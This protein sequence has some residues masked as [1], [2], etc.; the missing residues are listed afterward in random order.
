M[1]IHSS[2]SSTPTPPLPLDLGTV[3]LRA[4]IAAVLLGPVLNLANQWAAIRAGEI[5]LLPAIL[6]FSTPFLTVLA[7]QFIAYRTAV[8]DHA[9]GAGKVQFSGLVLRAAVIGAAMALLNV[10][11]IVG[12]TPR[13][14]HEPISL[15]IALV[16]QSLILP[17]LFSAVSQFL[18][19]RRLRARWAS[20]RP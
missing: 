19:H 3:I 20:P 16:L 6:F 18:T 9:Q 1:H 4:T 13:A 17:T 12:I 2:E 7:S 11:L 15:P 14:E 5:D 8:R 10:S